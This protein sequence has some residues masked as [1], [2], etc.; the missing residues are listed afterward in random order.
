MTRRNVR[1]QGRVFPLFTPTTLTNLARFVIL[2]ISC[3]KRGVGLG[4]YCLPKV[5]NG[6]SVTAIQLIVK[7]SPQVMENMSLVY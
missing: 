3:D 6:L 7:T 1:K 5:S 2:H 4:Q